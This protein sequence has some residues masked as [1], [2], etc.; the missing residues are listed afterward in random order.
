[1]SAKRNSIIKKGK[2]V[3]SFGGGGGGNRLASLELIPILAKA[4]HRHGDHPEFNAV[5][6]M[7]ILS[8]AGSSAIASRCKTGS[9]S[10]DSPPGQLT[11]PNSRTWG[12]DGHVQAWL[13]SRP[14]EPKSTPQPKRRPGRPRKAASATHET[15]T[16]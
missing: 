6:A 1:M 9:P 8:S 14:V 11:G 4:A 12:E 10:K 5:C 13:D 15:A 2:A 16:A 7:P 3:I